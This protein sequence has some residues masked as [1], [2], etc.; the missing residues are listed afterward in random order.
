MYARMTVIVI[1]RV[2]FILSNQIFLLYST[3]GYGTIIYHVS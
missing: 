3:Y 2:H 1:S